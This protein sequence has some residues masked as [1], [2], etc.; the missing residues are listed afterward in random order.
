M[1][2]PKILAMKLNTSFMALPLHSYGIF[3][4]L[5]SMLDCSQS[6]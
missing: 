4:P 2:K 1:D 5:V 6:Y 3:G